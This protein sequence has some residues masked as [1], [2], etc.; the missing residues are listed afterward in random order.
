MADTCIICL[1]DVQHVGGASS[2]DSKSPALDEADTIPAKLTVAFDGGGPERIATL[3]PC[4][5]FLHDDCLKPW[6]ERANSCPICRAAF[7]MVEIRFALGGRMFHVIT[8]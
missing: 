1:G 5:H 2:S 8:A 7:N 4:A 3:L 6:V